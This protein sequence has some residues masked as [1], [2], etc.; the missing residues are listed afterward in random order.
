MNPSTSSEALLK[1]SSLIVSA[2]QDLQLKKAVYSKPSDRTLQ[3]AVLTLRKIKQKQF[4]QIE[5]FHKDNKVTHQNIALDSD[6]LSTLLSFA[7]GFSQINVICLM[8]ECEY[9]R[10]SN[11]KE[12]LLGADK[13]ERK[14]N[15]S[16]PADPVV[17]YR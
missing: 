8:G 14:L 13:L 5:F 11:D 4:L 7:Q 17:P 9:R 16:S 6:C 3:K 10:S 15:T 12:V 2:G 1:I